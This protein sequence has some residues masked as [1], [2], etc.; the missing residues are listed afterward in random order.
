MARSVDLEDTT[1]DRQT[2]LRNCRQTEISYFCPTC[3]CLCLYMSHLGLGP[4]YLED[5]II[6]ENR[7]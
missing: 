2:E 4:F 5:T 1:N 6:V 3:A 7:Y